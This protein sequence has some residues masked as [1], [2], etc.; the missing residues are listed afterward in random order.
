[1]ARV[2]FY[3][4]A[5]SQT[6]L[7]LGSTV[8]RRMQAMDELKQRLQREQL[9]NQISQALNSTLNPQAVLQRIVELTGE[10]FDVDRV[11][12]WQLGG[13]RVQALHEWRVNDR[14]VSLLGAQ[15]STADWFAHIDVDDDHYQQSPFQ[16]QNYSQLPHSPARAALIRSA[17]IHSILR[18]PIFIRNEFFGSLS[19][20][21]E[22]ERIFHHAEINLLEQIADKAALALYNAQSYE[23][24]ERQVQERTHQLENEKLVSEA[25]NRAKSE[26]LGNMS[27]EL[28]TPLTSVIGCSSVLLE[29]IYGP[30][31]DRQQ[32]YLNIIHMSGQHL[33][34]LI[35]DVL[36]LTRIEVGR[37]DLNIQSIPIA[38]VCEGSLAMM[39]PQSQRKGLNLEL[40]I[41]PNVTTCWADYRRLRQILLNLLSNA[42]KFTD[43][44]SVQLQVRQVD[45]IVEFAVRD[46]GIGIAEADLARLFQPFE[47][48]ET[49]LSRRY[50]GV[51]L[52]LALSQRLAQLMGGEITVT[53]QPGQGSCF[54]LRL[55]VAP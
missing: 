17:Q 40:E 13:D 26:F 34:T 44:G 3:M 38:E 8:T 31:N 53:S 23:R 9:L 28:R 48:L 32:Q 7:L 43:S 33:L 14:V 4:L 2:Q 22:R 39:Q 11:V 27:H 6:A 54:T 5:V 37:E 46:T 35:N 42:I 20:H 50:E 19:L 55:P 51:G 10:N 16:T 12:V 29:Q 30:L 21:V 45:A 49:G 52:G 41:A 24:L 47:Q 18:V 15:L 1:L 36:D 25:A